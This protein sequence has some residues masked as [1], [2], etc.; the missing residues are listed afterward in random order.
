MWIATSTVDDVV[1]QNLGPPAPA[2]SRSRNSQMATIVSSGHQY[3][4][5]MPRGCRT[6]HCNLE[7][8]TC[9]SGPVV[10]ENKGEFNNRRLQRPIGPTSTNTENRIHIDLELHT[11]VMSA[12]VVSKKRGRP[13][14]DRCY[15]YRTD[16]LKPRKTITKRDN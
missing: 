11:H 8:A 15:K 10:V 7:I 16:K 9:F 2:R 4:I 5:T 12:T 13:N 3:L 14:Q 1:G 6:Y